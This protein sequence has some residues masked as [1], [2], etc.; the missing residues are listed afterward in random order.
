MASGNGAALYPQRSP[1][2]AIALCS[3][4]EHKFKIGQMVYFRPTTRGVDAPW[5]RSFQI[6]QR[7]PV[8]GGQLRYRIRNEFES[9]ERAASESELRPVNP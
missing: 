7:L 9:H 2:T 5:G 3:M 4:I 1:Q 8:F 6:T